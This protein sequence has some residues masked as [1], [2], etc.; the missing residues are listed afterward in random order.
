MRTLA[1]KNFSND[2]SSR[3]QAQAKFSAS[4]RSRHSSPF[5]VEIP[6]LQRKCACGGG[7]PRCQAKLKMSEPGDQYEQ[8]ADHIADQ[9]MRMPEP[10]IQRQMELEEEE[11]EMVQRQAIAKQMTP[12]VQRQGLPEMEVNV[13]DR[14]SVLHRRD[15][16]EPDDQISLKEQQNKKAEL[17]FHSVL[18]FNRTLSGFNPTVEPKE[19][20][21]AIIW[22]RV[23]NT[24]WKTAPEHMNRL[25]IYKA[26]LCSG[27]R[28]ERDEIFRSQISAPSIVPG[29]QQG[30]SE[31]ES[32]VLIPALSDGN[33]DTY[34]ELDVQNEVE[35]INEDNNST[36]MSF[37][38][39]PRN[40][41]ESAD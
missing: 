32:A 6:L 25:T 13:P 22:W 23:W 39:R 33:Y 8:E 14:S 16:N 37:R 11:E 36:F 9:V 40:E 7:C 31:Y 35:E 24:G 5:A 21:G 26:D 4:L 10:S 2:Y 1:T 41:S 27:C 19:D 18:H 3:K 28:Y 34:V 17:E 12:L 30:Q 20:E 29:T 38:V 15:L